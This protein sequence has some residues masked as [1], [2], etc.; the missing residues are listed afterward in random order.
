MTRND[1]RA[2]RETLFATYTLD[3]QLIKYRWG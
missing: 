1:F 2:G 3:D